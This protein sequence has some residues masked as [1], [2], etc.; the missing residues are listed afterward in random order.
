MIKQT[1]CHV[2]NQKPRARILDGWKIENLV[3]KDSHSGKNLKVK[4]QNVTTSDHKSVK[5]IFIFVNC[6]FFVSFCCQINHPQ[7]K[8]V[9]S[10]RESV[11]V[12]VQTCTKRTITLN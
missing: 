11:S 2:G 5:F 9:G 3:I 4:H 10:R 1:K 12:T 7:N 6:V 8:S